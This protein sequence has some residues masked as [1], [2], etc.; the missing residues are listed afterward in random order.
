MTLPRVCAI[1]FKNESDS[2][3]ID[4]VMDCAKITMPKLYK[5]LMEMSQQ[6]N[7]AMQHRINHH[8]IREILRWMNQPEELAGV[9]PF[10]LAMTQIHD[11]KGQRVGLEWVSTWQARNLA[12]Y[13]NLREQMKPDDRWLVIYG[14]DHVAQLVQW[15]QN[16][17]KVD[18]VPVSDFL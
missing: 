7:Q 3:T 17:R 6:R 15:L 18:L 4:D 14:A 5:W 11:A 13:A 1:D 2:L 12:I 16:S 10:Y 8:S 9:L